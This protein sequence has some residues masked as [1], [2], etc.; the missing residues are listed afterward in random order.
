MT[1][2]DLSILLHHHFTSECHPKI[3]T[4]A[5]QDSIEK[6]LLSNCLEANG[7]PD[8]F[9]ITD[10]GKVLIQRLCSVGTYL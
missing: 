9:I 10:N 4:Q 3:K 2:L 6:M 5:V 1:P 7:R 8:G